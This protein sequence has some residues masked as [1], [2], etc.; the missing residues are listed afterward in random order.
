MFIPEKL[1]N[2]KKYKESKKISEK[3]HNLDVTIHC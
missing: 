1:Y 2:T 3:F